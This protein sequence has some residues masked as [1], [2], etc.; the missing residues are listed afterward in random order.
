MKQQPGM[1]RRDLLTGGSLAQTPPAWRYISSA[2]VSVWPKHAAKV[3]ERL[4]AMEGVEVHAAEASKIV[5]L[6]EGSSTGAL[7][8]RLTQINL[9]DGVLAASLVFEQIYSDEGSAT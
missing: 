9:L 2:V 7:G 8:E 6:I 5:I 3:V 4:Q 1:T